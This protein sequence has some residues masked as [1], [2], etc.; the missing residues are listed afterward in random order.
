MEKNNGKKVTMY[1]VYNYTTNNEVTLT[2]DYN[3]ALRDYQLC[4]DNNKENNEYEL[5]KNEVFFNNGSFEKMELIQVLLN[6]EEQ[7]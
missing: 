4:L 2:K 7:K 3:Q 5:S 1:E 6:S